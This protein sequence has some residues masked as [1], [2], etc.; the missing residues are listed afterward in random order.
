LNVQLWN[1]VSGLATDSG[2][3][4]SGYTLSLGTPTT[5]TGSTTNSVTT[6]THS[7]A[8]TG[9][10]V[11]VTPFIDA[12]TPTLGQTAFTLSHTRNSSYLFFLTLNGVIQLENT[13]F[14]V[15]GTT[16]TWLNAGSITLKTT[17]SLVARYY[18]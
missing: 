17:D 2:M 5:C 16:L 11:A 14:T 13:D 9:F 6:S 7:H 4:T 3:T 10:Q 12:Y 18:Y 15:S 1:G 8:I